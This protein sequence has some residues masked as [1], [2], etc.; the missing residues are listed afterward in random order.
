MLLNDFYTLSEVSDRYREEGGTITASIEINKSHRIFDGHFP[1]LPVVPGVCMMQI[2]KEILELRLGMTF[3]I[4]SA[5]QVKFL[6]VLTPG[7]HRLIQAEIQFQS[8]SE[9]EIEITAKLY[10]GNITFFKLK[11]RLL[12]L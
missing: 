3:L 6:A 4:Q 5:D 2:I 7:Q 8:P 10:F 9:R 1:G 11:A 12:K